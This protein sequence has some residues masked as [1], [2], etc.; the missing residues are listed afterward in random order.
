MTL[1][2]DFHLKGI[3]VNGELVKLQIWDFAG[4]NRFKFLLPSYIRG[5]KGVIF[6]YD[7]TNYG[8][9]THADDWLEVVKNEIHYKLPIVFVGGKADLVHL[10][11]VSAKKAMKI[12]EK[13]GADG[14]IE[15][16]SKTGENIHKIFDLLTKIILS[17][18]NNKGI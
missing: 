12:A 15:C 14:F 16:S 17:N 5:A 6:M 8:S 7:I 10:K 1:G 3:E 4:E 13:K 18:R 2:V 9:L 11:E